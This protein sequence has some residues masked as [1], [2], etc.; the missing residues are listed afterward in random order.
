M[1]VFAFAVTVGIGAVLS[2]AV[3]RA[4]NAGVSD[5]LRAGEDIEQMRALF[6]ADRR[7]ESPKRYTSTRVR[8]SQESF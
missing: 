7:G 2:L 8:A 5:D 3:V 1:A 4:K 6:L